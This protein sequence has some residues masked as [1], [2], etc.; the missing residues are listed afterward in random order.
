MMKHLILVLAAALAAPLEAQEEFMLAYGSSG[1]LYLMR[2]D[3]SRKTRLT[4]NDGADRLPVWSADGRHIYY[5]SNHHRRT[6][7]TFAGDVFRMTLPDRSIEQITLGMADLDQTCPRESFHLSS[8]LLWICYQP[9]DWGHPTLS[10]AGDRLVVTFHPNDTLPPRL[11]FFVDIAT[12]LATPVFDY[13]NA[14]DDESIGPRWSDTHPAWS[15]DGERLAF[16]SN[17][18]GDYE[19]YVLHLETGDLR[20]ITDNDGYDGC[21]SWSAGG[22]R[23]VFASDR[24]GT[25]DIFVMN[26]DGSAPVQLTNTPLL[27][28]APSWSADGAFIAYSGSPDGAWHNRDIYVMN[29]DGTDSRR[30]TTNPLGDVGPAWSPFPL[31][32]SFLPSAVEVQSWGAIKKARRR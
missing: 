26:A 2:G 15:P 5:W 25:F 24:A 32:D 7:H 8:Y 14:F 9:G 17:R 16:A 21:P 3:G 31:P 27:E 20:Q 10:P 23:M 12:G 30:L 11:L 19:I 6:T 1:E 18:D 22:G 4:F 13:H 28:D 29:A